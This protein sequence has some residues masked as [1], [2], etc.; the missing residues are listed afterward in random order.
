MKIFRNRFIYNLSIV[1]FLIV[2]IFFVPATAQPFVNSFGTAHNI[3]VVLII[4]NTIIILY[5]LLKQKSYAIKLINIYIFFVLI[6]YF[7]S[8]LY[9]IISITLS[10]KPIYYNDYIYKF[11]ITVLLIIFLILV[12]VYKIK[13]NKSD[14]IDHI[15]KN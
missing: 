8:F 7:K 12:N 14:S 2:G 1:F 15:G 5:S 3:F 10:N 6:I 4:L 11:D 9:V 13:K